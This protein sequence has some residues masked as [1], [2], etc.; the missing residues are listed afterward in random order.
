M[1]EKRA[2][3]RYSKE[4]KEEAVALVREQSY[5]VAQAAE[6][7]GVTVL[8]KWKEKLE[9]QLE[10]T[11]LSDDERDE[12]KRL[13]KELRMEKEILKKASAFFAKEMK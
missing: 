10:G 4:F 2:Y 11:E 8:Y 3:K 13:R 5:S 9:V 7:V 1:T 6:A 12:L